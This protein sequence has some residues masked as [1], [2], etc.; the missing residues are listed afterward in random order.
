MDTSDETLND[1]S[2]DVHLSGGSSAS[3]DSFKK[4]AAFFIDESNS[5]DSGFECDKDSRDAHHLVS[6]DTWFA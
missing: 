3:E 1:I 4:K 5:Q 6:R 2:S